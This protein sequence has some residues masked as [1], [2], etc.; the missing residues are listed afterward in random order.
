[1][2]IVFQNGVIVN[3]LPVRVERKSDRF[4]KQREPRRVQSQ[5]PMQRP[6]MTDANQGMAATD[7]RRQQQDRAEQDSYKIATQAMKDSDFA[8]QVGRTPPSAATLGPVMTPGTTM[9]HHQNPMSTPIGPSAD[10]A[11][12]AQHTPTH[13]GYMYG[14]QYGA[15]YIPSPGSVGLNAPMAMPQVPVGMPSMSSMPSIPAMPPMHYGQYAMTNYG[16]YPMANYGQY[17]YGYPATTGGY[18]MPTAQPGHHA[19]GT[20][21]SASAK[22]A[23]GFDGEDAELNR[24]PTT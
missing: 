16:Q 12:P 18:P 19:G 9:G 4:D 7:E 17:L 15:N 11:V 2:L 6:Y 1:M 13:Y 5:Y 22:D 23:T 8:M 14:P 10:L 3:G 20:G 21:T 24:H